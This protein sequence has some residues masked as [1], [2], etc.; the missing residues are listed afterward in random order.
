M[1]KSRYETIANDLKSLGYS[2]RVNDLDEMLEY[3]VSTGQWLPF[4]KF[5]DAE[6]RTKMRELGYGVRGKKKPGLG[7]VEDCVLVMANDNRYN[8]IRDYLTN[9]SKVDYQP[10]T[11]G[12]YVIEQFSRFFDNP[13]GMFG[14]WL[15]KW[16][17]GAIAKALQAARN[18]MFILV[19][20][21]KTGKSFFSQWLCPVND[22]FLRDSINPDDKDS[23]LR[24]TDHFVWEVE[25]LGATTRRA[26]VES[27]KAFVTRDWV[28]K[29]PAFGKQLV[30]K[31]AL[32]SFV[33]TVNN[34]GAGFLNDFTGT[35]RFLSCEVNSIDFD[36]TITD[37][38]L[39]WAEAYHYYR[40]VP[41][42]WELT[43]EEELKQA[44]INR[45]YEVPS[46]L[47]EVITDLYDITGERSHF[48][49]TSDLKQSLALHYRITSEQM[50]YRELARVLTR[51]GC[52]R[53]REAYSEN[54]QNRRGWSGL[55]RKPRQN[56]E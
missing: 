51:L 38:N 9:L 55:K 42:C 29:R 7:E 12:P 3:L 35:T 11:K 6:I 15:F 19:G 31:P 17:T 2:F 30:R 52:N 46:A 25:E 33:G 54:S 13:D 22:H 49:V 45:T 10:S 53:G 27:L 50:F 37:V 43:H 41:G 26:D 8:P 36:Y 4:S 5:T 14:R 18:P 32:C 21:Q 28:K 39:L 20:A 48:I 23:H 1:A 44:E 47:E 16:M 34:D 24:L 40:T 56:I